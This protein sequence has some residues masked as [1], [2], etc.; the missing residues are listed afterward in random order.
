MLLLNYDCLFFTI[1]WD[2]HSI[3][4]LIF[5]HKTN[6][7]NKDINRIKVVL[8]EKNALISGWLKN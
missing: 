2:N 8:A 5:A 3:E 4:N 6:G 1:G 7:M